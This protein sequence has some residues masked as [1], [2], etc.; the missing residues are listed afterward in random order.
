[1]KFVNSVPRYAVFAG[2]DFFGANLYYT[3]L[4]RYKVFYKAGDKRFK[5][6]AS[7]SLHEKY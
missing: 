2:V 5:K 7:F 1:M 6:I 4:R 3:K